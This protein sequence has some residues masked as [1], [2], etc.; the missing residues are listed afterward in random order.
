MTRSFSYAHGVRLVEEL[1]YV[2]LNVEVVV[3]SV[4]IRCKR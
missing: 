2:D 4:C 3:C 1:A